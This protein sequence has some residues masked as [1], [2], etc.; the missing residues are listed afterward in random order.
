MSIEKKRYNFALS[1]FSRVYGVNHAI[2]NESYKL[3]CK[4]WASWEDN[5]PLDDLNSVDRYF[6]LLYERWKTD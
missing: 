1:S 5:A 2:A 6:M 3:F 4:D